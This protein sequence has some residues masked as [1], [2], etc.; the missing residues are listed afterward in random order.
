MMD[1]Q[2]LHIALI[3]YDPAWENPRENI[4][5]LT[6]MM[7]SL[8][9]DVDV[10]ILPEMFN[11]G[12]TMNTRMAEYAGEAL[13]WMR[14]QARR[15]GSVIAG[16]VMTGESGKFYNRFYW[17][18]PSAPVE[19]YDKRHLFSMGAEH[20]YMTAGD[21]RVIV[22]C[23]G[24]RFILQV[25]YDLRFPV[26]VRNAYNNGK[27]AYDGIIYIANWPEVRRKAY[28]S[29]LPARAIENQAYVIWVNRVGKDAKGIE[30]SGDSQVLAPG[31]EELFRMPSGNTGIGYVR[32]D[33]GK[34]KQIRE[35]FQV[36]RDWDGL[37][38]I[39]FL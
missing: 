18:S 6:R 33:Y 28:E 26:F 5:V 23:K 4:S 38:G 22:S 30:H 20:E 1:D 31:G 10:V 2:S 11:T 13:Q 37:N 35:A 15:T 8:H 17:V 16:S 32:L 14:E 36:A 27:F 39:D 9:P 3:Q 21:R 29:L 7:D 25:C 12:F 19:Y 24:M 34:L